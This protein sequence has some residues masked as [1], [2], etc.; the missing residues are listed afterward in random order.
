MIFSDKGAIALVS[1]LSGETID[2]MARNYDM[3][4]NT[5]TFSNNTDDLVYQYRVSVAC[6]LSL[7]VGLIQWLMGFSGLGFLISFFSEAF[8]SS[9]TSAGAIHV[10]MS[11][12]KDLFGIKVEKKYVG[13]LKIPRVFNF[14]FIFF[15][16]KLLKIKFKSN[17]QK[18]I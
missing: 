14:Y 5:Q 4:V 2:Q 16:L 3:K 15:H 8:V 12:L 13:A 17:L 7:L 9:Y 10:L 6:S 1:L 18:I 11:Q